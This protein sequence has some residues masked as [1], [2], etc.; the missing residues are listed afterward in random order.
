MGS[1]THILLLLL[2]FCCYVKG[3]NILG[4]FEVPSKSLHILGHE[5]LVGLAKRG[6]NVTLISSFPVEEKI[7]NYTH[8]YIDGLLEYKESE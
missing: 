5:M 2:C 1:S 3:L 6:Y 7:E 4:I 8:V